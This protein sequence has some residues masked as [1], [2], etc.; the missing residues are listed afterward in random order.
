[1]TFE[2]AAT[3]PLAFMTAYHGLFELAGLKKGERVLIHAGAGGVGMAAVQL[4]LAM[5]AQVLSTAGSER[6]RAVLENMGVPHVLNSRTLDFGERIMEFTQGQGVQVVLNALTGDFLRQSLGVL[7]DHGRFIELGKRE[8]LTPEQVQAVNP[9]IS[10]QAFD[11]TDVVGASPEGRKDI[12]EETFRGFAAGSIRP[13]PV[14]VFPARQANQAFHFMAQAQH[15]GKICLS[16]RQALRDQ[17]LQGETPLREDGAYLIT[18][19]LGGLGL[20]LAAWMAAHPVGTIVLA[21]RRP[22]GEEALGKL[23]AMRAAGARILVVRCDVANQEDCDRLFEQ[24][25]RLPH[26]LRGIVHAAGVLKDRSI[27]QQ[28]WDDFEAVLPPKV[29][30][31]WNLHLATQ[32]RLLDF[33]VLFSSASSTIGNR[34]QCNYAAANSF[35]NALAYYRRSLGMCANSIC[36]GPWAQVGMAASGNQAGLKMAQVGILGINLADGISVM[37]SIIQKDLAV[38]TVLDMN[39]NLFMENIPEGTAET[40]FKRC[41]PGGSAGVSSVIKDQEAAE[42]AISFTPLH[43]IKEAAPEE[44]FALVMELVRKVVARVMGYKDISMVPTDV[45]LTRM[46]LDSLMAM[47]FRNQLIKRLSITLPSTLLFDQST[48]ENIAAHLLKEME[49]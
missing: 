32:D 10:Y 20:E 2:Q 5:G 37:S 13:L 33:F 4:A 48:L 7:A 35:M 45:S 25:A 12:L 11:L 3:V 27:A 28:S 41:K 43:K 34:G 38:P 44:R 19:G 14:R 9:T 16:H 1:L 31:S 39:W 29:R 26:P 6:K 15:I 21:G 8:I 46:G 40:Y 18:G 42:P 22:P 30:G 49:D 24:I 23:E 47:D 36:W 17:H